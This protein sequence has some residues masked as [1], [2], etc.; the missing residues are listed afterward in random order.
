M[1][2]TLGGGS[3]RDE[4]PPVNLG[5]YV[6]FDKVSVNVETRTKKNVVKNGGSKGVKPPQ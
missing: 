5:G 6:T 1:L 3:R 2:G 4:A